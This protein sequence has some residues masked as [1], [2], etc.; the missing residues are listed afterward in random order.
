[1][2]ITGSTTLNI[3]VS[4]PTGSPFKAPR[5]ADIGA[6]SSSKSNNR[7]GSGD[8][9]SINLLVIHPQNPDESLAAAMATNTFYGDGGPGCDYTNVGSINM[10]VTVWGNK[11]GKTRTIGNVYAT[12]YQNFKS[13]NI[14]NQS[15]ITI[16]DGITVGGTISGS[17]QG[18]YTNIL[19]DDYGISKSD[20]NTKILFGDQGTDN[21]IIVTGSVQNFGSIIL[22]DNANVS[23]KYQLINGSTADADHHAANY[24]NFGSFNLGNNSKLGV[25]S[26]TSLLSGSTLKVG[27]NVQLSSPYI[28]TAGLMNFSNLRMTSTDSG[29][30]WIPT[31]TA[32]APTTT[33]SGAYWG[34]QKGYPILTFNGGDATTGSGSF[35][36]T[37]ANFQGVDSD[38]NYAFLGDYTL[39]S[40]STPSNPTWIGYVVSG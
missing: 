4:D 36:I 11:N 25:E 13:N 15:N 14:L 3:N 40:V 30:S 20:K 24:S 28:N 17:E 39:S 9:S 21:P 16:G 27:N 26:T 19:Y 10:Y 37:P 8:N 22:S 2:T 18:S 31:G 29:L 38:K 32:I 34:I 7:V 1:M 12:K 33:Y 35:N 23:V 5:K 6:G